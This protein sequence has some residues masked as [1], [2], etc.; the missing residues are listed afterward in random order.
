MSNYNIQIGSA[1]ISSNRGLLRALSNQVKQ[2]FRKSQIPLRTKIRLIVKQALI[3]CPEVES[4]RSGTLKYDF[5]LV[6]DYTDLLVNNISEA[7]EIEYKPIQ[8]SFSGVSSALVIYINGQWLDT[9]TKSSYWAYIPTENGQLPWLDWLLTA[10]DSVVVA[11]YSVAYGN[12][13]RSGGAIMLKYNNFQ[14]NPQYSGTIT[15]NFLTRAIEKNQ[16][17]IEQ[18][19]KDF[20]YG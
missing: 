15:D 20:S 10:G 1:Q 14:V 2:M 12:W 8:I 4:L 11:G 19:L 7:I 6:S 9:I 18:A 3:N 5:G 13:G 17:Q 16:D